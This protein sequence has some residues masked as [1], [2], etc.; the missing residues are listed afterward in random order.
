[1][2]PK[3]SIYCVATFFGIIGIIGD[4]LKELTIAELILGLYGLIY[5]V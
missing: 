2:F 3:I 4:N 1:M 5:E